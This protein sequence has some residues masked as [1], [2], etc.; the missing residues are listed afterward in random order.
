MQGEADIILQHVAAC[1][2][3][4]FARF[5]AVGNSASKMGHPDLP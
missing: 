5:V 1:C 3:S 2:P 4:I